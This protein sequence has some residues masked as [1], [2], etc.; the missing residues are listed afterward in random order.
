MIKAP[1]FNA[2]ALL[3]VVLCGCATTLQHLRPPCASAADNNVRVRRLHNHQQQRFQRNE[4]ATAPA[5]TDSGRGEGSLLKGGR[6]RLGSGSSGKGSKSKSSK[7]GGKGG[8]GGKGSSKS[9]SGKGGTSKSKSS[10]SKSSGCPEDDGGYCSCQSCTR[11][12]LDRE[13]GAF[14]CG[15]RIERLLDEH[16]GAFP[17]GKKACRRVAGLEFPRGE[18]CVVREDWMDRIQSQLL[19]NHLLFSFFLSF[20]LSVLT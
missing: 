18:S 12:V 20:F 9:K 7:C 4:D 2:V 8:K 15:E 10:K 13:V 1:K 14:T 19:T 16:P 6:R 17:T 3:A 11:E 5:A